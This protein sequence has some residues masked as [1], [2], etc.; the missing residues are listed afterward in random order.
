[1]TYAIP[2]QGIDAVSGMQF[3]EVLREF[4]G[5]DL[6]S[7]HGLQ[8]PTRFANMLSELTQCKPYK[9]ED[10]KDL[11]SLADAAE[12]NAI[13]NA[14]CIK[15]KTFPS[16]SDD[17][18]TVGPLP[19]VSL[20]NHHLAPFI[21]NAF[22][23]YVPNKHIAGLSKFSRVVKHFARQL[24]I[25]EKLTADIADY[26]DDELCAKGIAVVIRAEHMCMT[27]RGAQSPGT[28]TTTSQ[29][30]GVFGDHTRTA[31]AEFMQLIAKDL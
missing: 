24:Q 28:Q 12:S 27:I 4:G 6:N 21:G 19:F 20:C 13:H 14:G 1:M 5:L 26:L 23:G 7:P 22:V 3:S 17:M 30:R 8:T 15:W 31:K 18:I 11:A 29:M 10:P 2:L 16:E 9:A 25:Q